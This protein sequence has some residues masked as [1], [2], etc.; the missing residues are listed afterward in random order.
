MSALLDASN[1]CERKDAKI[2]DLRCHL[3]A[4]QVLSRNQRVAFAAIERD[5]LR[6][7]EKLVAETVHGA[8]LADELGAS[9]REHRA[10]LEKLASATVE[11]TRHEQALATVTARANDLNRQCEAVAAEAGATERR[12]REEIARLRSTNADLVAAREAAEDKATGVESEMAE[13]DRIHAARE[14]LS[15]DSEDVATLR[16]Q[17]AEIGAAVVRIVGGDEFATENDA[18]GASQPEPAD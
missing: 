14:S 11:I 2:F 8:R 6:E 13:R 16:R 17:I 5:L 3:T 15:I 4:L 18:A 12:L 10:D 7:G 9:Q 1:R